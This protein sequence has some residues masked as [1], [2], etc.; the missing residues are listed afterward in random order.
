MSIEKIIED[1]DEANF[2]V[3]CL[4]DRVNTLID[5]S[6]RQDFIIKGLVGAVNQLID[7]V[8]KLEGNSGAKTD[9]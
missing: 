8:K 4:V 6:G 1:S 9:E 7:R 5:N 3:D 2:T